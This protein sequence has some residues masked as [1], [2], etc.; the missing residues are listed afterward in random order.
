MHLLDVSVLIALCDPSHVH[1]A[2][3]HQWFREHGST[4]WATCPLTENGL[5]RILGNPRYPGTGAGSPRMA[6]RAL[7]GMITQVPGYHFFPDDLSI[8]SNIQALDEVTSSQLTD[9]YLILLASLHN[10]RFLTLDRRINPERIPKG[11]DIVEILK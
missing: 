11:S 9:T 5:L 10:C 8:M 7:E 4:G 6:A 2:R 3:A 1:S